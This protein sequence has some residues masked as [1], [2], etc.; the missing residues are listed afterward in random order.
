MLTRVVDG[1]TVRPVSGSVGAEIRGLD[2]NE[3]LSDEILEVLVGAL[4][5]Y[6]VLFFSNQSIDAE[7]HRAFDRERLGGEGGGLARGCDMGQGAAPLHNP[8]SCDV[9]RGGWRYDVVQP[10][11]SA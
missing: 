6:G 1:I 7:A 9:A 5:Q 8:A 11:Q 3:R 10:V 2:L 4:N